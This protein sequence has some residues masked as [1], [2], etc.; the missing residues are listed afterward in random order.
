[1]LRISAAASI[2]LAFAFAA[3]AQQNHAG[4]TA[5]QPPAAASHTTPGPEASRLMPDANAG[6]ESAP[7]PATADVDKAIPNFVPQNCRPVYSH[8]TR[9][10]GPMTGDPEKDTVGYATIDPC[11]P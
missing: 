2:I 5:P 6:A 7:Q 3:S 10:F 9:H 4:S 1:M 11:R 8:E